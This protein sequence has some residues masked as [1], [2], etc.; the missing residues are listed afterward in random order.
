[1]AIVI[2]SIILATLPA[3]GTDSDPAQSY[4]DRSTIIMMSCCGIVGICW[5][6]SSVAT[7]RAKTSM[8][9]I[10]YNKLQLCVRVQ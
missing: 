5:G 10:D 9:T 1:M 4:S 6:V 3:Y 8:Q 2:A 7:H